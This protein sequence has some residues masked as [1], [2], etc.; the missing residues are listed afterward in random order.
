MTDTSNALAI[1]FADIAQS[2]KLYDKIGNAAAYALISSCIAVMAKACNTNGGTVIKT[3]GD[4]IMCS[5]PTARN[6]VDAAMSMQAAVDAMTETELSGYY[7]PDI[8]VGIDYGPVIE[9]NADVFGDAVNVAARMVKLAKRR[10]IVTTREL[11]DALPPEY[12]GCCRCI[13][14]VMVKG[15]S[16]EIAV[17]EIVW[18]KEKLTVALKGSGEGK[19]LIRH[20]LELGFGGKKFEVSE[21]RTTLTISR[22]DHNDLVVEDNRVS[23]F[24]ARIEY[25]KDKCFIIDQST[26]GTYVTNECG[27]TVLLQRDEMQLANNGVIDLCC[28]QSSGSSPT[29]ILYS[30]SYYD[31][32][33]PQAGEHSPE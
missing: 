5:F 24:H 17:Y 4:E 31:T 30:A 12:A 9:E 11:V 16:E 33:E 26:N 29:A 28:D 2:T 18:E 19:S 27:T 10:Q 8:Y 25:R 7:A 21:A 20:R 1:M 15:K 14:N 32:S 22:L 6:A 23:R 13:E 3:I